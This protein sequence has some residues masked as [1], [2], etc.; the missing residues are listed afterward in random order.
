MSSPVVEPIT[1]LGS[2]C[3]LTCRSSSE[4]EGPGS[5]LGENRGNVLGSAIDRGA[6]SGHSTPQC[7]RPPPHN[8]AE[9]VVAIEV[10]ARRLR[11]TRIFIEKPDR[12]VA[13]EA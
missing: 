7:K 8:R 2:W 13:L 6:Y 12:N 3:G 1:A 9:L 10:S 4:N 5:I 11:T